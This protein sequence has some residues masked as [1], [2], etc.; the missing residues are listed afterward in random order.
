[1]TL[2]LRLVIWFQ[3]LVSIV[4]GSQVHPSKG[5]TDLKGIDSELFLDENG[6]YYSIS[7]SGIVEAAP[8]S[9]SPPPLPPGSQFFRTRK[10]SKSFCEPKKPDR[11]NSSDSSNTDLDDWEGFDFDHSC[12]LSNDS[13]DSATTE[14]C[15]TGKPF[16][17]LKNTFKNRRRSFRLSSDSDKGRSRLGSL[18]EEGEVLEEEMFFY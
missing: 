4:I 12:S 2:Y 17:S 7:E 13:G 10:R 8:V 11:L 18:A 9:E 15:V 16:Q 5:P 3:F 6:A 1:M 14:S